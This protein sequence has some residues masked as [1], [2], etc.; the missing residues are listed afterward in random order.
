MTTSNRIELAPRY[1]TLSVLGETTVKGVRVVRVKCD[2]GIRKKVKAADLY[3]SRTKSCGQGACK[4]YDRIA[5]DPKYW[6]RLPRACTLEQVQQ[7]W[8]LYTAGSAKARLSIPKIA[9]KFG[10]NVNTLYS[11]FRSVRRA[12][13]IQR[14]TKRVSIGAES[15]GA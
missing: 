14:Y 13:G 7:W 5:H 11:L 10:V 9:E 6:P 8:K 1:G 4:S 2:C 3:M 15:N 12:G